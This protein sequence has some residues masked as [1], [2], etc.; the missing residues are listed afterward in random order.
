MR[1]FFE[2]T[3]GGKLLFGT[4]LSASSDHAALTLFIYE[5]DDLI[6]NVVGTACAFDRICDNRTVCAFF[7]YLK[8]MRERTRDTIK[9]VYPGVVRFAVVNIG[10]PEQSLFLYFRFDYGFCCYTRIANKRNAD[11]SICQ[12]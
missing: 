8:G 11:L 4:L 10:P 7:G 2:Q 1:S 12:Y 5:L 9:M 6:D 3:G